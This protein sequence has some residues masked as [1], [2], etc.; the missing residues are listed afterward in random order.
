LAALLPGT[1]LGLGNH[2]ALPALL[3][4]APIALGMALLFVTGCIRVILLL[5][6]P[7]KSI[8]PLVYKVVSYSM[9]PFVLSIVPFIGPVIGAAWFFAALVVGCR[10]ALKLS[11]KLSVFTPLPPVAMLISGLAWYFLK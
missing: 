8:F 7:E 6:V 4:L 11:W 10:N 2:I 1:V 3:L 9:A 5:F